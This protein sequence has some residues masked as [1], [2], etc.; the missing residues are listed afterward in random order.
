MEFRF[1]AEEEAFRREVREFIAKEIPPA[2]LAGADAYDDKN[3][4]SAMEFRRKLGKR[5]WIGIGWPKEY[6][7]LGATIMMQMLFHEEM[8][9]NHAPLDG[10]AYQV[11]PAIFAH[12]SE[13]LKRRFLGA[14]AR[15]E[16]VWCQGFSEPNAGS[17]LASLQ[18]R[19]V[20]DGDWY[21]VNGQ[22]I[23][24][25]MAHRADWVHLLA[26]TDPNAPKHKGISYFVI[27]MKTPGVTVKP[28]INMTGAHEFNQTFYDNV[29]VP[30]EN[31]IGEEN[32]GWYVAS[33]TLDNER[34]GI[35]DVSNAR[36][37]MDDVL[38]LYR[39]A[40]IRGTRR[41]VAIRHKPAELAIEGQTSRMLS[42]RVAWMQHT[43]KRANMEASIAKLFA[44][45]LQQRIG[46]VGIE[47][48]GLRGQLLHGDPRAPMAGMIPYKSMRTIPSTIAAGTSEVNRNII[49]SRGLGMPRG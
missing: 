41:D 16:I 45:E 17:D 5:K 38:A 18:T 9:Y 33:L 47:L 43:G 20:R 10:Q 35:R 37:Q 28:L 23:W 42:Y 6:G 1:T 14:T 46:R 8:V 22:K 36:R 26:R 29:R 7:G 30:K 21:V 48:A 19:A 39:D 27:D 34:S 24:T 32:Q 40:S 13:D 11:G 31:M 49:A 12:G 3:F 2:I 44:S 25:T 15:Q 4:D